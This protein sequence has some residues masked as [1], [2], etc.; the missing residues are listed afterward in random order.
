LPVSCDNVPKDTDGEV[1]CES[2]ATGQE[3]VSAVINPC[4]EAPVWSIQT[5]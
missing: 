2:M 1:Y 4:I 3:R 5:F